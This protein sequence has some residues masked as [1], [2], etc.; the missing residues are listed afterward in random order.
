MR[1]FY[2]WIVEHTKTVLTAFLVLTV[3]SIFMKDL[4]EVDYDI[5]DYLPEDAPSTVALDV[6]EEEFEGGI[7]NARVMINDLTIPQA[8]EYKEKLKQVDGVS[9]VTWLDDAADIHVPLNTIDRDT[10][11]TYYKDNA[12]LFT[13]TI[14]ENKRIQAVEDIRALIGEDNAMT[15]SA[16]S[17]AVA[18]TST[19]KEV[20]MISAFAV[21]FVLI[22]LL[23]TTPSWIEPLI[24]LGGLGVAI[25]INSGTNLIFGRI[26][27]VTNAAGNILQL[28]VSLDYSVFL[29]HRFE[30]CR[31]ENPDAKSAMVDALMKSTTSILS[32]GLT[33][34]I[35]FLALVLMQF[36][37]GPDLGLALAK[38]VALSLITVFVFMPDLILVTYRLLD[39]TRHRELVPSCRGLGKLVRRL[40]IPMVCVFLVIFIPAY[41]ASN[42]ND[43]YYGASHIFG[44]QTQL[45]ADTA[46]IEEVFGQNDTYVLMVP[47]NSTATEKELSDSLHELPQV[48]SIISYV[49]AAG[50]EIPLEYLDADTLAKLRSPNYSRMV[51]SLDTDYEGKQTF[52]LV[53]HRGVGCVRVRAEHAAG[54]Q[55]LDGGLFLIHHTDLAAAGLGAQN[56]VIRHIEGIL[57]IAGWVVFGYVQAGKVVVI[58]LNFGAFVNFKAHAGKH[59]NDL[60]LDL[61]D[62][63]QCAGGVVGAGQGDIHGFGLVA[64]GKLGLF[65]LGGSSLILALHPDLELVDG[66]TGGGAFLFGNIT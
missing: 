30:E 48:T 11:E 54:H 21:L 37:I 20:M 38:G 23:I 40:M 50:A 53:E 60:I 16:V 19:V 12:A 33:T 7:P 36:R 34:V 59:I 29:I 1:K 35:G 63:M 61:G 4:V 65:D 51:I 3:L 39:K 56:N 25:A 15:G 52:Q 2:E 14:D 49:D 43:Y 41:L 28:A 57:H 6:M 5:N 13:V 24:V 31:L 22:V 9:E 18:T 64:G 17:T 45:G 8:L 55:N 32:S 58:V 44:V 47:N 27:F 66:F 46:E 26:S 62:R 10:L 42:Q